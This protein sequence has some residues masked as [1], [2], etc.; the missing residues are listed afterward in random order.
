MSIQISL[1]ASAN[2]VEWWDRFYGSLTKNTINWE[3]IF[4]GNVPPVNP[5]PD[6]FRW[7]HATCKPAQCYAIGFWAARGELVGWTADDADYNDPSLNCPNSLDIAYDT[8]K[9]MEAQYG[10]KKS[11]VAM[12]PCEDGGFPQLHFHRFFGGWQHTPTM[13]PFALINTD[14]FVNTLKGYDRRFVSGQSENDVL[15]RVFEDGGRLQV[16][17]D[18]KLYV[19]HR[20]VHRR[21][22]ATGRE[23][24]DF[25]AWYNTDREVLEQAWVVGG[26]GFYERYNAMKEGPIKEEAKHSVPISKTRLLVHEPF[27]NTPDVCTVTQG[28]KGHWQ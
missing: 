7:I 14:Y 17:L 18:A 15:M 2:R 13:A 3:V 10:D 26:H 11:A 27:E 6:N 19:H 8:Y 5:M 1:V 16:D 25:R 24:N 20:Q 23:K 21:D 22:P 4:V 12:N 28:L 9:K